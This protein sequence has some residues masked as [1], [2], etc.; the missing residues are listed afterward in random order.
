MRNK[1][2]VNMNRNAIKVMKYT[3][4]VM[5]V[6]ESAKSYDSKIL[7]SYYIVGLTVM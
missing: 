7:M 2:V 3:L 6:Y 5:H 4:P 1:F